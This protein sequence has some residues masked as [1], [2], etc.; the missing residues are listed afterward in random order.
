MQEQS[1]AYWMERQTKLWNSQIKADKKLQ[2]QLAKEYKRVHSQF[3]KEIAVYYQKYGKNNVLDFRVM[4]EALTPTERELLFQNFDAFATKY[5]KYAKY[6]GVRESIYKLNRLEGLQLTIEQHLLELGAIEE[7]VYLKHLTDSYKTGYLATMNGLPN[8]GA[9][10]SVNDNLMRLTLNQKWAAGRNYSDRI[11]ADK[12]RLTDFISNDLRDGL[13]RGTPYRKMTAQLQERFN[14]S[15]YVA[16]RLVVS[17]SSFVLNQANRRAFLD[18]GVKSY[19]ITAVL[20][21]RTTEICRGLNG[22]KFDYGKDSVGIT[23]P[24]FHAFCRTTVVPV[25]DNYLATV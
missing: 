9:F 2:N 6:Q 5:P 10:F 11:W 25:L 15:N 19:E 12:K 3:E 23:Y 1:R 13:H 18:A 24:P 4:A 22:Q 16:K 14:T 7:E 20:D 17:E 8:T 21:K